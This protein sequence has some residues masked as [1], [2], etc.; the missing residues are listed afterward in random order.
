MKG[1]LT[2]RKETKE[3]KPHMKLKTTN[4]SLLIAVALG[5]LAL[6]PKARAASPPTDN[7]ASFSN[8][9]YG[10]HA[11]NHNNGFFDSAFGASALEF[12]TNGTYDTA[13]GAFALRSNTTGIY[14]TANGFAALYTNSQ[15]SNNTATG[16]GALQ[17]NNASNNTAD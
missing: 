11:L 10:D 17:Q 7:P 5:C 4:R 16:V 3:T 12:N 14:N 2:E 13:M 9:A 15:G 8:T 6:L 1:R